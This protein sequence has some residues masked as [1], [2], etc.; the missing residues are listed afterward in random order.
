M[1]WATKHC[2]PIHLSFF[3]LFGTVTSIQVT[4]CALDPSYQHSG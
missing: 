2:T 3:S 4:S 1:P